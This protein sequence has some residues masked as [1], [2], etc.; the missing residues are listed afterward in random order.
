MQEKAVA[1]LGGQ[2]AQRD[3]LIFELGGTF[4]EGSVL[5]IDEG[6]LFEVKSTACDMSLG[7]EDLKV[8]Q[9]DVCMQHG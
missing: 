9:V 2:R 4:F 1:Y 5:P 6:S 3:L 7:S 8:T